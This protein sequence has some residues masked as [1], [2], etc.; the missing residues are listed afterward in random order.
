MRPYNNIFLNLLSLSGIIFLSFFVCAI[1]LFIIYNANEGV[2]GIF[3]WFS[4][5]TQPLVKIDLFLILLAMM[6]HFLLRKIQINFKWLNNNFYKHLFKL[7]IIF[8][9]I[10]I[11]AYYWQDISYF[12][13]H[14]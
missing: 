12:L 4:E 10:N 5:M 1:C 6:N 7:G 9:I 13:Y 2:F 11:Y 14:K 8:A 3:D